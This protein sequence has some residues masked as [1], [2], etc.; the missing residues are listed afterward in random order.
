MLRSM[1]NLCIAPAGGEKWGS[2]MSTVLEGN[3]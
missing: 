1:M 3:P 2:W